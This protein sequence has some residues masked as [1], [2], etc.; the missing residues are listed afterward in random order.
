M[1]YWH[2]PLGEVES[3]YT[4]RRFH[5]KS[6]ETNGYATDGQNRLSKETPS[7]AEIVADF[8]LFFSTTT[9]ARSASHPRLRIC[10]ADRLEVLPY[11]YV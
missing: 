9:E 7:S 11:R 4:S 8:L 10:Q 1:K 2:M 6:G 3:A 5:G